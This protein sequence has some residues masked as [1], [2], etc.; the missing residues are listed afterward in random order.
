MN[1][2]EWKEGA[3]CYADGEQR[4]AASY[5]SN[6][7]MCG[8]LDI[9]HYGDFQLNEPRQGD[10]I[11]KSELDTEQK[12]N[13]AVE[14]FGLFGFNPYLNYDL[15]VSGFCRH[16]N[17]KSRGLVIKSTHIELIYNETYDLELSA[18]RKLTYN[19][20]MAIG[21]LKRLMNERDNLKRCGEYS[22]CVKVDLGDVKEKEV[23]MQKNKP[24]VAQVMID[25]TERM[26]IGIKT[27]GEAL[28]ASNGRDALQDAYEEA[29]DLACYLKQAMIERDNANTN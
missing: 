24:V 29:L 17:D 8:D 18:K 4:Y 19:Q 21:K 13:D 15:T 7:L 6:K 12:Y 5:I 26:E 20:L 9:G 23:A 27:Y 3:V 25:L 11:P 16:G 14:V 10:Y 1:N 28:R 2:I 22:G